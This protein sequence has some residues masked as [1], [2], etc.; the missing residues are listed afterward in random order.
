[1]V[2]RFFLHICRNI[3]ADDVKQHKRRGLCS[4]VPC[5]F[6]FQGLLRASNSDMKC[7]CDTLEQNILTVLLEIMIRFPVKS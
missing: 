2:W 4:C 6:P 7:L 5:K 3:K 1:M